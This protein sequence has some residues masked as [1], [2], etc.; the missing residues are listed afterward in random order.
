MAQT[1]A[2]APHIQRSTIA[3]S[4]SPPSRGQGRRF[5]AGGTDTS[6]NAC[7]G[8]GGGGGGA[9]GVL[10]NNAGANAQGADDFPAKILCGQASAVLAAPA[11][12][13]A[14][15]V[16]VPGAPAPA[17]PVRPVWFTWSGSR[18]RPE[19][20]RPPQRAPATA[21]SRITIC[22]RTTVATGQPMQETPWNG[23]QPHWLAIQDFSI[24]FVAR[25]SA[26]GNHAWS[27]A[28]IGPVH[29]PGIP[30][31]PADMKSVSRS[32]ESRPSATCSS[33]IGSS[34][35]TP[36]MPEAQ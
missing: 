26:I 25:R 30:R 23:V 33:I 28:A 14:A 6:G 29:R 3:T 21:P 2:T 15:V 1:A 12:V 24:F 11:T 4:P 35:C 10:L 34:V 18:L 17:A 27:P 9:G 36:V 20:H 13:R 32:S 7:A 16:P 22:P 5:C 31:Q 8:G 19:A